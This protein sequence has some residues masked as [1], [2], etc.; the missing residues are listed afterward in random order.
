M[1][2][3]QAVIANTK[4]E[5]TYHWFVVAK[6]V[7]EAVRLILPNIENVPGNPDDEIEDIKLLGTLDQNLILPSE[8]KS[9]SL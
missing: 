7:Q 8:M 4:E 6:N 3:Y 1:R 2:L 9:A 5:N